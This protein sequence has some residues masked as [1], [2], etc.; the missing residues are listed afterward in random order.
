MERSNEKL[1][2][3]TWLLPLIM[4]YLVLI[5]GGIILVF[6][7]SL[8]YIPALGLTQI[9]MD[10]Y[11]TILKDP[12]FYQ[13][14]FYAFYLALSASFLSCVFGVSIAY[15]LTH[16][17]SNR[18]LRRL[19]RYGLILPYLYMTFVTIMLFSRTGI[20]SRLLFQLNIIEGLDQFP[21]IIYGDGGI[22]ILIVFVLKGIP[23]VTLYVLNVMEKI[24]DDY[25]QVASTLG[26][27][28][29][30]RLR[31]VY[32]PLSANA[33]VWSTVIIFA[34]DMGAFEVPF[35]FSGNASMPLS[36]KLYGLYINPNIER[37]PESMAA[38]LILFAL[39]TV[40]AAIYAF[41]LKKVIRW[42]A[43]W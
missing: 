1:H 38:T 6:I 18:F 20:L 25:Q 23:F 32:L 29:L 27:T 4:I 15:R 43:K 16:S 13:S 22:G 3:I 26:A 5:L 7:E 28:Y 33:I 12:S 35:L 11:L 31:Y 36:V 39:G 17:R 19:L 41:V 14:V 34:Y 9:N 42:Q 21:Q 24:K 30:Q 8:G 10:S 2:K 37:I 40:G